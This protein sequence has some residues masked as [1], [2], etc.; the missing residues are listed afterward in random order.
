M[1]HANAVEHFQRV[2]GS[3]ERFKHQVEL[4][5]MASRHGEQQAL[6]NCEQAEHI[7]FSKKRGIMGSIFSSR[8]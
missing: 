8:R 2:L 5:L 3:H 4:A 7:M 6:M 1:L